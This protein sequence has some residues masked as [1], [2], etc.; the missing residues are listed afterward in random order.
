MADWNGILGCE[1][2]DRRSDAIGNVL[3][4][5]TCPACQA[6]RLDVIRGAEYG[7]AYVKGEDTPRRVL[8]RQREFFGF[9][10]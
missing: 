1:C 4:F 9:T 6:I 3:S 8:L 5:Q 10:P 7:F 2:E